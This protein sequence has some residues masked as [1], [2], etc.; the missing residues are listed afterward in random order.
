M[1]TLTIENIS[2]DLVKRLRERAESH[3]RSMQGELIAILE[4]NL[5]TSGK[6]SLSEFRKELDKLDFQTGDDS[7]RWIRED[8]DAR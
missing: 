3:R 8:R 2:D 4:Q 5:G 7:T 6:L 1:Q